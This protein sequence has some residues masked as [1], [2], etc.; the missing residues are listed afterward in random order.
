MESTGATGHR[1]P[2]L[3]KFWLLEALK[4]RSWV[5]RVKHE[6]DL[7]FQVI[8]MLNINVKAAE[9]VTLLCS[10]TPIRLVW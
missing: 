5:L 9:P 2:R 7:E 4:S 10:L 1:T 3:A 6:D 8:F